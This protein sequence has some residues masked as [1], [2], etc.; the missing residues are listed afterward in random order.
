MPRGVCSGPQCKRTVAIPTKG[1][2]WA[3]YQ[4][5]Y[6]GE[7]LRVLKCD[8]SL[9]ELLLAKRRIVDTGCWEWTAGTQHGYGQLNRKRHEGEHL[10]HRLAFRTWVGEIPVG[11]QI[12]HKC[13]NRL[14]F[15]PDH[16]ERATQRANVGE[17]LARRSYEA[18]IR[19]LEGRVAELERQ[20]RVAE[21]G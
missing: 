10:V 16:L 15:N 13:S 12:H 5:Q 7:E 20:L 1:L 21:A 11:E 2:C 8:Q 3:H 4:Q 19:A 9:E 17:M 18:R 14:C 6:Q